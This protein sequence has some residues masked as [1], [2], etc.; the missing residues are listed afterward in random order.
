MIDV[1][2]GESEISPPARALIEIFEGVQANG[3]LF[4]GYPI[5]VTTEGN[6]E[7]D[8]LLTSNEYG[9]VAFDLRN[10]NGDIE[11]EDYLRR[12]QNRQDELFAAISSKLLENRDLVKGRQLVLPINVVTIHHEQQ[13]QSDDGSLVL[14]PPNSLLNYLGALNP[15][16]DKTFQVLNSVIQRTTTLRPKK[17]RTNVVTQ[18]SK[19]AVLKIIDSE[20]ANLDTWQKAAAIE[21]PDGV[22]RIRG[23]AGSGKTIVLAQKASFL[24]SKYPDWNIAVT[25]HTR[26]LY[27]QFRNLIRRFSF[28]FTKDEPDWK[29]LRV[30]HSW[31]GSSSPGIYSE[32]ANALG[33]AVRDFTYAKRLY[34]STRAFEGV[35]NELLTHVKSSKIEDGLPTLFDVV[36]IDEAQDLPQQF[37]EL[38]YQVTNEPKR[39]VYAYDELQNLSDYSMRPASELFGKKANG[40]PRVELRNRDRKPKQDIVLPVCYR[41]TPWALTTAH[42]LGFG[43]Y[44]NDGLVQMFDDAGLWAD[45]GYEASGTGI[46]SGHEVTLRRRQDATPRFFENIGPTAAVVVNRFDDELVQY[47]WLADSI[48]RNLETD[49]LDHDDILIIA[50]NALTVRPTAGKIIRALQATKI[51]S[52]LVGV[53][54]DTD[55]VFYDDSIAITSIYRAKGNEAPMVYFVGAEYCAEGWNLARKRNILFTAITRSR[56]WVQVSGVGAHMD[57]IADEI[58]RVAQNDY[59]LRF[60][61]PTAAELQAMRRLHRDRTAEEL[62]ELA[63]DLDALSRL[64]ERIENKEFSLDQIP[65]NKRTMLKR[66]MKK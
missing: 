37:F 24:H 20:I 30:L 49:E 54:A 9:L 63:D 51:K 31:G 5:L 39:V 32:I 56:A 52:H 60:R 40:T 53:T 12:V 57:V 13:H 43:V 66:L 50:S 1:I 41:N 58:Q 48:K 28:E 65:A 36:L 59:A 29:K 7:I 47:K 55:K 26:S 33:Q 61:Y 6:T 16:D 17:R 21:F 3:T 62:G 38:T 44:R 8:A 10:S 27:Q 4:L 15:I 46:R 22:Q 45:I 42:A 19:G 25:F 64:L 34:G 14:V 18:N 35:C 11:D 23:L 2:F